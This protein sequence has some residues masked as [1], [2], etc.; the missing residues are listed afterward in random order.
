MLLD[1]GAAVVRRNGRTPL[2]FASENGHSETVKMFLGAGASVDA[3]GGDGNG[4]NPLT[5]A[6]NIGHTENVEW[7]LQ[8]E[9]E[10]NIGIID[11]Y[12]YNGV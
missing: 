7:I 10:K 4:Y 9:H 6:N 3:L 8:N 12:Y 11:D 2:V 1:A 5:R